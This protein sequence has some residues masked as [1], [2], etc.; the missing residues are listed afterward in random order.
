MICGIS[1][2]LPTY[3]AVFLTVSVG[4]PPGSRW[5]AEGVRAGH[6][7]PGITGLAHQFAE[8]SAPLDLVYCETGHYRVFV[9]TGAWM[10]T[11]L[12]VGFTAPSEGVTS[13]PGM[14]SSQ[15]PFGPAHCPLVSALLICS[16]TFLCPA[17]TWRKFG[18]PSLQ[19]A[20][21]TGLGMAPNSAPVMMAP[22]PMRVAILKCFI[23]VSLV[24]VLATPVAASTG[25]STQRPTGDTFLCRY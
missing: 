5:R 2:R 3:L 23:G 12:V 1:L 4:P 22:V 9:V 25:E 24:V 11:G 7:H 18:V 8:G 6:R 19:T 13:L 16:C 20:K 10:V 15:N 21:A 17:S 14:E